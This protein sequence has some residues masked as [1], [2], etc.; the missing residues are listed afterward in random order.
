MKRSI[1]TILCL[2]S[3]LFVCVNVANAAVDLSASASM[4]AGAINI[5]ITKINVDPLTPTIWL[6]PTPVAGTALSFG[7]LKELFDADGLS[8]GV[9]GPEGDVPGRGM[10]YALDI[11]VTGGT[12]PPSI[13]AVSTTWASTSNPGDPLGKK[14]IITP[15]H[16][17]WEGPLRTD[18]SE[19]PIAGK[20]A[21]TIDTALS[22][23]A[24]DFTGH[25]TRLY[26]GV[27]IPPA[28]PD[29][30]PPPAGAV[31]FTTT[32]YA[33]P[34]TGTLTIAGAGSVV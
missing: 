17:T 5:H 11:A 23:A 32:S 14:L 33:T 28:D 31:P 22:F 19:L 27:F 6:N 13:P 9:F 18:T 29:A 24:A 1:F 15:A 10:Y 26:V 4:P 12:Y 30:T 7:T 8:L 3:L 34:Y 16:V 21:V 2:V 20:P 25:W